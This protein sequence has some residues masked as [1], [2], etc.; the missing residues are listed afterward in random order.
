MRPE[1]F[2][3]KRPEY[4]LKCTAFG[5]FASFSGMFFS[6]DDL[7]SEKLLSDFKSYFKKVWVVK[8]ENLSDC[9]ELANIFELDRVTKQK[10]RDAFKL[11]RANRSAKADLIWQ[12]VVDR[13]FDL[14]SD[15]QYRDIHLIGKVVSTREPIDYSAQSAC[16]NLVRLAKLCRSFRSPRSNIGDLRELEVKQVSDK[17]K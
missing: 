4:D 6:V 16:K 1:D 10:V 9:N 2:F 7:C 15:M 14:P 5:R 12:K 8:Y 11:N 17:T 13:P 3:L